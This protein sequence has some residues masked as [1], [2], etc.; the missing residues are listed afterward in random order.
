M[1]DGTRKGGEMAGMD[2]RNEEPIFGAAELRKANDC[3]IASAGRRRP[4]MLFDE[5][6][7]EGELALLFG[8]S[9]TGKSILAT[10]IAEALARGGGMGSFRMPVPGCKVLYLDLVNSDEQF[11]LRYSPQSRGKVYRF[12]E[13]LVRC[14]PQP[15]KDLIKGLRQA[16]AST[17]ARVVVIDDLQAFTGWAGIGKASRILRELKHMC[18]E[19]EVSILAIAA[20]GPAGQNRMPDAVDLRNW[21]PLCR[22]ADSVFGIGFDP[23]RAGQRSIRHVRSRFGQPRMT[24]YYTSPVAMITEREDGFVGFIFDEKFERKLPDDQVRLICDV[25]RLRIAGYGF[26]EIATELSISR[27]RAHRLFDLWKPLMELPRDERVEERKPVEQEPESDFDIDDT[28][29]AYLAEIGMD[30][31]DPPVESES[32]S[33]ED[34]GPVGVETAGG[35]PVGVQPAVSVEPPAPF[36]GMKQGVDRTGQTIYIETEDK[37]GR[38]TLWYGY[39]KAGRLSRF[40]LTYSGISVRPYEPAALPP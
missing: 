10:Q 20:S 32:G 30:K 3:F 9:D 14:S 35:K 23:T 33:D 12:S 27:S 19:Q 16:I 5:F 38:P 22:I 26:R 6:W 2:E 8:E 18:V 1:R 21:Q 25:R 15:D 34:A 4:R 24:A 31:L 37:S 29:P 28:T 36:T 40:R 17:G 11:R 39:N 13:R 7:R